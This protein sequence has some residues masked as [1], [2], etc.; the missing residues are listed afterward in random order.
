MNSKKSK[1]IGFLLFSM[2]C[3]CTPSLAEEGSG[4]SV[5]PALASLLEEGD[6]YFL[7]MVDGKWVASR[8]GNLEDENVAAVLVNT[9]EKKIVLRAAPGDEIGIA[10]NSGV[11]ILKQGEWSCARGTSRK[12]VGNSICSSAFAEGI[13]NF[14]VDQKSLLKASQSSGLIAM[15]EHDQKAKL[16]DIQK[17]KEAEIAAREKAEKDRMAED[18]L[19][20]QGNANAK[21]QRGIFYLGLDRYNAE[22]EKWFEKAAE[23]G[24]ADA[25][26]RLAGFQN[27]HYQNKVEAEHLIRKAAQAGSKE[28]SVA[29]DAIQTER[30]RIAMH[31]KQIA[32]HQAKEQQQIAAFRKSIAGGDE[33]N[34]GPIIEV[35]GK[36]VKVAVAVANYGN[37]HWVRRD[38]IYPS[39]WGCRF[40]NGQYQPP[41]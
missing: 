28:A 10:R 14:S 27:D 16:A 37:E 33:S 11:D 31:E 5:S 7:I 4:Y 38:E 2:V 1:V 20:E 22:A 13:F 40:I 18:R 35:K 39:G 32:A 15:A 24:H 30:K 12:E 8:T 41:Q 6:L 9:R 3:A 26:Y 34:C 23:L 21:F 19:A 29:L 36:L 25:L 17:R